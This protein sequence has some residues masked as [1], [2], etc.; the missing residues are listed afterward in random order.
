MLLTN[1]VADFQSAQIYVHCGWADLCNLLR[2]LQSTFAFLRQKPG[3][4]YFSDLC[5]KRFW[6]CCCTIHYGMIPSEANEKPSP[7]LATWPWRKYYR[8]F[9]LNFFNL[10]QIFGKHNFKLY[11]FKNWVYPKVVPHCWPCSTS[12]VLEAA[13]TLGMM[14]TRRLHCSHLSETKYSGCEEVQS[15]LHMVQQI[16]GQIL[17]PK[18]LIITPPPSK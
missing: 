3:L 12:L 1:I 11:Y 14:D 16:K 5:W 10:H 18:V 8:V 7:R 9:F 17:P 6:K 13:P 4:L 15:E 2:I